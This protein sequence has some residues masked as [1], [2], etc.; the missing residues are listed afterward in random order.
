MFCVLF[1][2]L[3][4]AFG[5]SKSDPIKFSPAKDI[6]PKTN[7]LQPSQTQSERASCVRAQWYIHG[8]Y[9]KSHQY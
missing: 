7:A 6:A 9:F 2:S 5:A 8:E 3:G 1:F 4:S